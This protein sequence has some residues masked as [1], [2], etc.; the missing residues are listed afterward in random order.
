M[1]TR[2]HYGRGKEWPSDVWVPPKV[3]QLLERLPTPVVRPLE[4]CAEL[5]QVRRGAHGVWCLSKYPLSVPGYPWPCF[6]PLINVTR[7]LW[8][9]TYGYHTEHPPTQHTPRRLVT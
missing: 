8:L 7:K 2:I 5:L 6:V 4:R 1:A 9:L 3:D